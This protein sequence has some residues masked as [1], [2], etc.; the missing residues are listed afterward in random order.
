MITRPGRSILAFARVLRICCVKREAA[1][2]WLDVIDLQYRLEGHVPLWK[3]KRRTQ[4]DRAR[5]LNSRV[6]ASIID[7][8]GNLDVEKSILNKRSNL[9][10]S[11]FSGV[12]AHFEA[13]YIESILY[14][15]LRCLGA[16]DRYER[17]GSTVFRSRNR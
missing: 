4:S 6:G 8:G 1:H 12:A 13:F 3:A 10:A 9:V 14:T 16:F 11:E 7:V 17:A 15:A 2:C 5:L